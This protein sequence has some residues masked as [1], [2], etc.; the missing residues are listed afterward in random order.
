MVQVLVCG[1]AVIDFVFD[2]DGFPDAPQKYRALDANISLG[3]C[4]AVA[5]AAIARLKG[6]PQLAARLGDD[7]AGRLAISLLQ[8]AG[9]D[10][11]SVQISAG[12]RSG[13]SSV[14]L[15]P[16]GER[17]IMS[18]RGSGLTGLLD[19]G[20][21]G[22][23][24]AVLADTR[25]P[26]AAAAVLRHARSLGVPGVLDG[27]TPV[28][29]TLSDLASHVAFSAQGVSTY[30]GTSSIPEALEIAR[31]RIDGW[32]CATDGA[33]GTYYF[34][35]NT[36]KQIRPP[37]VDIVNTLGAG[38]VWHGAFTLGLAERESEEAAIRFANTAAA[39]HCAR[40][41]PC[42]PL[43]ARQEVERLASKMSG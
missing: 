40:N 8:R 5:A 12:G 31:N 11:E 17:Q 34:E 6:R 28:D 23:P 21:L 10:T 30:A 3:G 15:D 35:G 42:V 26:E 24:A 22:K 18:F 7:A 16:A 13:Y 38:D 19:P 25:W 1:L 4:A 39:L 29:Q 9:I 33:N 43:P 41:G 27:E 32:V 14:Y 37:K 36:L 2:V 20:A